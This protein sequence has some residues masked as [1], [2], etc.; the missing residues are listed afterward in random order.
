VI[1]PLTYTTA[2]ALLTFLSII[3][4]AISMAYRKAG[5]KK[6]IIAF[7]TKRYLQQIQKE[8]QLFGNFLTISLFIAFANSLSLF[9]INLF[10]IIF[11]AEFSLELYIKVLFYILLYY[12]VK[13]SAINLIGTL[14]ET[15]E[16]AETHIYNI[17]LFNS[18]SGIFL[19]GIL[20]FTYFT[21]FFSDSFILAISG[22]SITFITLYK[23]IQ[24]LLNEKTV[25]K[26][27]FFYNLLYFCT[28]EILP[29]VVAIKALM[30]NF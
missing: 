11:D 1:R 22:I 7:F 16:Q 29:L 5:V 9:L 14:Y 2:E 8:E 27:P 12:F 26:I 20:V 23:I 24:L 15:R 21:Y 4:L 28:L 10:K 13:F 17:F 25:N 18:V 30:E 3:L 6:I 19:T